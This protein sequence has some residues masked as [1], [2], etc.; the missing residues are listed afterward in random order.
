MSLN[1]IEIKDPYIK[2]LATERRNVLMQRG[3]LIIESLNRSSNVLL[4][5]ILRDHLRR[6]S[7]QQDPPSSAFSVILPDVSNKVNFI[8]HYASIRNIENSARRYWNHGVKI[9]K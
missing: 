4:Y 8:P 2:Y 5:G 9:S 6:P 1:Q 7:S 3:K